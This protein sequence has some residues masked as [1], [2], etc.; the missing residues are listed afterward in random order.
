MSALAA[1]VA[2]IGFWSDG[3][4]DWTAARAFAAG[5]GLPAG[6]HPPNEPEHRQAKDQPG[7]PTHQAACCGRGGRCGWPGAVGLGGWLGR[8]DIPLGLAI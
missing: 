6:E 2:G 1:T 8:G 7:E 5:G 3:L 4:P